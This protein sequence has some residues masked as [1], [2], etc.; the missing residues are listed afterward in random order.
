[1]GAALMKRCFA[2]DDAL[3]GGAMLSSS[4][5]RRSPLAAATPGRAQDAAALARRTRQLRQLEL[6][7]QQLKQLSS[8]VNTP[9]SRSLASSYSTTMSEGSF[10]DPQSC[11]DA[12]ASAALAQPQDDDI[13]DMVMA[14][15]GLA[16]HPRQ[17]WRGAPPP[18]PRRSA[19]LSSSLP[20]AANGAPARPAPMLRRS[21]TNSFRALLPDTYALQ[22]VLGSGT[23]ST[24]YRCE[25]RADGAAFACKV[26]DKRRLAL[27][28]R[29]RHDIAF[30]LRR[31]VDVLKRVDHPNIARLEEAFESDAYL[32]LIM[33]LLDGGELFDAIV[34]R[35]RFSER[36]A[37][38][39]PFA[40]STHLRPNQ[41]ITSLYRLTFPSKYWADVSPEA[42]DLVQR[43]L[44]LNPRK[45][46][47]AKD[48]LHHVWLQ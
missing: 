47:T 29:Q 24:C 6:Q 28:T 10:M 4:G 15:A 14:N 23:T 40:A 38:Q 36:E 42:R 19:P 30:Q 21:S 35:G 43:I 8:N 31:E 18:P 27:S 44:V 22:E 25:R 46:L 34:E 26:I 32:I 20:P 5:H 3:D 33:E 1:M 13:L 16:F 17:Q 39:L 41:K 9:L 48:A 2:V 11:G 7:M 12:A 37:V 45:R